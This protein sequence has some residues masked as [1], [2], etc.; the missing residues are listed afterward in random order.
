MMM[1][2]D[3]DGCFLVV[4]FIATF[5]RGEY[6]YKRKLSANN[7]D[8]E[9]SRWM[10]SCVTATFTPCKS[11]EYMYQRK[12]SANKTTQA[13]HDSACRPTRMVT[14]FAATLA[15]ANA[16]ARTCALGHRLLP[17]SGGNRIRRSHRMRRRCI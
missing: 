4:F 9:R 11:G 3:L 2:C 6:M 5:T 10:F 13:R 17:D 1:M 15:S 8:A 7:D 14:A 16:F 12:L